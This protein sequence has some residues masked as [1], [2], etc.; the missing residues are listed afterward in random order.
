MLNFRFCLSVLVLVIFKSLKIAQIVTGSSG[1]VKNSMYAEYVN[2]K[3]GKVPSKGKG[4]TRDGKGG[5]SNWRVQCHDFWKPGGCSQGRHC[6]KYHPRRQ[7]G[8]CAICGSTRHYT[9]QCTR[10]VK[11]KAKNAEW[12]DTT[13]QQE[14]VEWRESTWDTEEYE[15]FKGKK[16]KGKRSK[17]KGKS[18]GKGAPRSIT[19]R[20][21][22][23]HSLSLLEEIDPNLKP[24]PKHV[25]A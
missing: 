1:T 25:P 22:G 2:A 17:S 20:V 15:A 6:P 18:K 21:P 13:W 5:K 23:Q 9:S 12:D 10:P 19:P 11:P 8:R 16:G 3:K 14:E 4:K 24:S 7:P